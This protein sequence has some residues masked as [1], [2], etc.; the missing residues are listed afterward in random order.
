M[1]KANC[2]MATQSTC[3]LAV[4]PEMWKQLFCRCVVPQALETSFRPFYKA[5]ELADVAIDR[6][7]NSVTKSF[8]S[9]PT[10]NARSS[11]VKVFSATV[12][13]QQLSSP[14]KHNMHSTSWSQ[15]LVRR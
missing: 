1:G 13:G 10:F 12:L 14:S 11:A 8:H 4:G 7:I 6:S 3:V 15:L 2:M 9:P 5:S